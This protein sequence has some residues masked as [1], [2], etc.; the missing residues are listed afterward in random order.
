MFKDVKVGDK[1][2]SI[3]E[4]WG[5]VVAITDGDYPLTIQFE[6]CRINFTL[7]GKRYMNSKN[8]TLFWDEVKIKVLKKKLPN[9]EVDTPVLVSNEKGGIGNKRYFKKFT[10]KGKIV[11]FYGGATSWSYNGLDYEWNY[12]ELAEDNTK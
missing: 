6:Y 11:C 2:Y 3:E 7:D 5:T 10:K 9:L 8:P 1:L 12:W 4:E